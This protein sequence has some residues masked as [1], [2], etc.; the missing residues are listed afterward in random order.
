MHVR[1]VQLNFC[2]FEE[3][4]FALF[5][6]SGFRFPVSGFLT[7]LNKATETIL[8]MIIANFRDHSSNKL[9][10][11]ERIVYDQLYCYYQSGFRTIHSTVTALLEIDKAAIVYKSLHRVAP[12]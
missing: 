3:F 5:L 12:E 1:N 6:D 9:K 11:F 7:F 2:E 8:T 10:G 4:C